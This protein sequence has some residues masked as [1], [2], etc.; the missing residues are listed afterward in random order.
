MRLN[1]K[2]TGGLA[3][4]GLVLV[5]AVPSADILSSQLT[6]QSGLQMTADT[7]AIETGSIADPVETYMSTGKPL[8]SYISDAPPAPAVRTIPLATSSTQTAATAPLKVTLPVAPEATPIE[9]AAIAPAPVP[10]PASMRPSPP[11][12]AEPVVILDE[13]EVAALE[14]PVVRR[15]AAAA[16]PRVV[17]QD[18]LAGWNSGTLADYLARNGL[19]EDAAYSESTAEYDEDGFFLDEGPN[20]REYRSR[21]RRD[22]ADD[23]YFMVFPD[24]F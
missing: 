23:G 4:T 3:W 21:S 9:T 11:V 18:D 5:L 17:T 22:F 2:I 24:R 20:G 16:A 8:P 14:A 10:Y 15:P 19:L 7:D 12:A 6:P 13:A 1:S